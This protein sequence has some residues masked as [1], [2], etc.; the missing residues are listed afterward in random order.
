[1]NQ[2]A[3]FRC[4]QKAVISKVTDQAGTQGLRVTFFVGAPP[5]VMLQILWNVDNF[6]ALFP[7]ILAHSIVAEGESFIDVAYRVNA[8]IKEVGYVLRRSLDE[9]A[10]TISWRE[11][12]GDLRRVRGGWQVEATEKT[13]LSK[14]TYTAFVDISRLVPS[15]L[16]VMGAKQKIGAMVERIRKFA[17][18]QEP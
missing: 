8:V 2:E 7:E 10:R 5:D 13:E 12:S 6:P 18:R 1:M 3:D 14:I 11:L 16:V 9:S 4:L 15:R 17:S